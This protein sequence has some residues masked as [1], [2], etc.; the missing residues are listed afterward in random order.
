MGVSHEHRP[1]V[2]QGEGGD[3][4]GG[5]L[6]ERAA[7]MAA[8]HTDAT[9]AAARTARARRAPYRMGEMTVGKLLE[10]Q[11]GAIFL[12]GCTE[13]FRLAQGNREKHAGCACRA[14]APLFP[15]A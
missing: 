10:C 6:G 5:V 14:A 13:E 7:K 8:L 15:V 4:V 1:S 9:C 12:N 11:F 2:L 3:A